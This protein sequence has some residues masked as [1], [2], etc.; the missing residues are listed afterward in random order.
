MT[1]DV[2]LIRQARD[3]GPERAASGVER[4][5]HLLPS[6]RSDQASREEADR[7]VLALTQPADSTWLMARCA[8]LLS[9]YFEKDIDAGIRK[10]DAEDWAAELGDFPKWAVEMAVRWWKSHKNPNRRKRPIEGDIADRCRVEMQAVRAAQISLR[11]GIKVSEPRQ[12]DERP[13]TEEERVEFEATLA[14]FVEGRRAYQ[15][16]Q[17]GEDHGTA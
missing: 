7:I 1:T 17:Q 11:T 2:A 13:M 5:T 15:T 8:A 6:L 12:H 4:L 14:S 3:L 9:P 10:M 16:D